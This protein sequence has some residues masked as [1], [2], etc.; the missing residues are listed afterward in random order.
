MQY[1]MLFILKKMGSFVL[2]AAVVAAF[3]SFLFI[4]LHFLHD[5]VKESSL[6]EV[7]QEL[8]LAAIVALHLWLMRNPA[9]RASSLLVA[10]FFA[11]MLVREMDFAFDAIRHG[12]WFW[13]ATAIALV[14]LAFAAADAKRALRGL[15][16]YFGHPSYGLVCAGL[17]NVLVFSRLMGIGELWRSLLDENYL[18]AI[19]NAVEEGSELFGYCLCL[20]AT[21][22]Y[23]VDKQRSG[24]AE[25]HR[26]V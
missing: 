18:R 2:Y 9:L 6:T 3:T 7:A 11:C 14:C 20:L 12:S 16:G 19:K 17:L 24:R 25:P 26:P 10:G 5:I 15:A 1:D 22:S 8:V 4:D 21:L 13:V 23:T